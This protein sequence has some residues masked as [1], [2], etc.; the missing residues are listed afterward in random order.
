MRYLGLDYGAKR[1]GIAVSDVAGSFAFPRETIPND[2]TAIDRLARLVKEEG[3]QEVVIG[4]ARAVSGAENP[5]TAESEKFAKM[6]EMHLRL[7]VHSVWE[8][9][10][11]VEAARF[12]PKGKEHDDSAAAAI[13]LQRHLDKNRPSQEDIDEEF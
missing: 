2:Y 9:W 3:V 5:I 12:A 4:D 11:S 10:S 6:I 7:P 8:A 13:I 1:I